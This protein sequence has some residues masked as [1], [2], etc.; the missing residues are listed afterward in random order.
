MKTINATYFRNNA[1]NLIDEVDET[2][3]PIH[4]KGKRAEA[5]LLSNDDYNA[6]QETL[7]ILSVPGMR[8]SIID[9]MNTPIEE[10]SEEISF[11]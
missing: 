6:I 1:Y 8:E 5:V 2:H 7:Y 11:A 4:V 10:C 9:G 3:E